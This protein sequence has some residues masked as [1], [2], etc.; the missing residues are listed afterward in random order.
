MSDAAVAAVDAD[1]VL[2]RPPPASCP[3]RAG[4]LGGSSAAQAGG[5]AAQETCNHG[6]Y[7]QK[8]LGGWDLQ[9]W[10][11]SAKIIRGIGNLQSW[12][13]SAKN[14]REIGG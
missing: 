7:Q 8:I 10:R 5:R 3:P 13:P 14:I 2:P 6:V 9:S 12:R 4:G 11:P 1:G